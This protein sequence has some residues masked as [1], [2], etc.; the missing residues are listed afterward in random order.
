MW[1]S[2]KMSTI[3][4]SERGLNESC[5]R[6]LSSPSRAP[7]VLAQEG[8]YKEVVKVIK[9]LSLDMARSPEWSTLRKSFVYLQLADILISCAIYDCAGQLVQ[10]V[11]GAE[12]SDIIDIANI[13]NVID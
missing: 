7:W 1:P 3:D 10:D 12:F 2:T 4:Q 6:F 8:S 9:A 13:A 11:L 5:S